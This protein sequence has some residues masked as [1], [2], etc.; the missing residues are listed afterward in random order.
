MSNPRDIVKIAYILQTH[1]VPVKTIENLPN[2]PK[3]NKS[4]ENRNKK[5]KLVGKQKKEKKLYR[6]QDVQDNSAPFILQL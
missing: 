6:Y 1:F 5:T 4:A 3:I 2:Y